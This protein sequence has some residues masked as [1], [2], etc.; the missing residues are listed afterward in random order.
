LRDLADEAA[1]GL[2]A[3]PFPVIGISTTE[4]AV[5]EENV[6][7]NEGTPKHIVPAVA[8]FTPPEQLDAPSAHPPR[9]RGVRGRPS[10]A[11]QQPQPTR[12]QPA[13]AAAF[14][15]APSGGGL[16]PLPGESLSGA[17]VAKLPGET[18]SG[19]RVNDRIAP[20]AP[21]PFV[22]APAIAAFADAAEDAA[23]VPEQAGE[24]PG[25]KRR[26]R[27]RR[28]RG[29]NGVADGANVAGSTP[30]AGAEFDV[31]EADETVEP[32]I[33]VAVS[34]PPVETVEVDGRKRRRRR[35][36]RRG[37]S[38]AVAGNGVLGSEAPVIS[39]LL[40]DRHIIRVDGDGGA[41]PT[42]QNA[43]PPPNRALAP[44]N[45]PKKGEI[46]IEPP[47][48]S[49]TAPA[50]EVRI[51]APTRRRAAGRPAP[52]AAV[53]PLESVAIKALPGPTRKKTAAPAAAAKKSPAVKK[54]AAKKTAGAKKATTAK[55]APAK[56]AA[57]KKSTAVKAVST[58]KAPAKKSAT[59]K[60][61]ARKTPGALK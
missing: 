52:A 10:P 35:R 7:L 12:H 23:D 36:R 38:A 56:K 4:E 49:L 29:T 50:E 54:T 26:R 45:R 21:R 53:A 60:K 44:W 14:R 8:A 6:A 9:G 58:K 1:K 40:P 57:A 34:G 59:A 15:P 13:A 48:P 17:L 25:R 51:A 61:T 22:P 2:G 31:E 18:L 5:A 55:K 41:Q 43:P 32:P 11:Q 42:G 39:P 30:A 47:P 46:A 3:S 20:P 16:A 33:A 19:D 24:E 27:R 28:G 37:G